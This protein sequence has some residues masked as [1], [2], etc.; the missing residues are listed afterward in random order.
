MDTGKGVQEELFEIIDDEDYEPLKREMEDASRIQDEIIEYEII[1][2][3]NVPPP[4]VELPPGLEVARM[5]RRRRCQPTGCDCGCEAKRSTPG[6]LLGADEPAKG[7][8][9]PEVRSPISQAEAPLED[10]VKQIRELMRDEGQEELQQAIDEIRQQLNGP[11][12]V[13]EHTEPN[14]LELG[15]EE[16]RET[17]IEVA[18]DSGAVD[19]VINKAD[20]PGY[21]V[22]PSI[23]SRR[24]LHFVA[25]NGDV[26][27]N[28]GEAVIN[29]MPEDTK[30]GLKSTFQVAD[31][32]RPLYSATKITDQGCEITMN[33]ERAIVTKNGRQIAKFVRKKGLYLCKM[34]IRMPKPDDKAQSSFPRP[35]K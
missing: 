7:E 2:D 12:L 11:A 34:A 24:G 8:T 25:A 19:H 1:A 3:A 31:V 15:D 16:Y 32:S 35:T 33:K 17:T 20:I 4:N 18:L 21:S 27:H 22:T 13:L 14:L 23:G 26:I 29:L 6:L 28:R 30:V 9:S 5:R 10:Y